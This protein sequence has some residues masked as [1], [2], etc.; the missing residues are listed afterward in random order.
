MRGAFYAEEQ[1][2]LV[3]YSRD[4][5]ETYWDSDTPD[6]A[7]DEVL[8]AICD[9]VGLDTEAFFSAINDQRLQG[10]AAAEYG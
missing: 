6:I 8:A 2:L 7:N 4:V 1:D 10:S 5:F 3:P 9:R